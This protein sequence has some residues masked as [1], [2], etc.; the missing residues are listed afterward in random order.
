LG[1]WLLLGASI[2]LSLALAELLVRLFSPTLASA[3]RPD[4]VLLMS[5]IPGAKKVYNRLPVNGGQHIVVEF[6]SDGFRGEPL[7]PLLHQKRVM[8]YGDSNVE[9]DFSEL[10]ATFPK[11][12]ESR[13]KRDLGL[14]VETVNAGVIGYGPDQISL[15]LPGE[16]AKF[17]PALVVV[18]IFADN[19]FGDLIR[20]R[21]YRLNP[22]GEL[23]WSRYGL[24]PALRKQMQALA[25]PSGLRRLQ[26][27]RY[28]AA[29]WGVLREKVLGPPMM[30]DEE[31]FIHYVD[32]SLA[33]SFETFQ[34]YVIDSPDGGYSADPLDDYYDADIALKPDSP[35]ARYKVALMEKVLVKLRDTAAQAKTPML[36]TI[37]PSPVDA[38]DHYDMQVD[39]RRYPQYDR[40]RLS[41]LVED[42][43]A[44]NSIPYLNL[45]YAF[46]ESNAD[47]LY[48]RSGDTHWND[49]GQAEAARLV[50]EMIERLQLLQKP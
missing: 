9:A 20:H 24:S 38:C 25:Y 3:Y 8:V 33:Q 42:M 5:P 26:L 21:I 17:K 16:L 49:A 48:F 45:W 28:A 46:R 6:N 29:A 35:S 32:I 44:R 22:Q 31:Y 36:L 47:H 50:A 34:E 13:L 43:A 27:R 1:N 7:R 39:A 12:L 10:A 18:V 37:L 41:G 11:Q 40:S 15:R 30:P 19:D 4:D 23:T 2:T 14:D